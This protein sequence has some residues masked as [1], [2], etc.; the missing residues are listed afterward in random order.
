MRACECVCVYVPVSTGACV[1]L[2]VC[3]HARV[4]VSEWTC[5]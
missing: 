3:M 5:A 1:S 4:Y 2:H